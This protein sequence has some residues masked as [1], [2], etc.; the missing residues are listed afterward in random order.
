MEAEIPA[1]SLKAFSKALQCLARIGSDISLEAQPQHLELIGINASRSAYASFTFRNRF[2][3]AYRVDLLPGSQ[4]NPALRCRVLAKPLVGI[5][6]ARGPA[7]GHTVEKCFLRIEQATEPVHV[8]HAAGA[9]G[10]SSG[11]AQGLRQHS[12][13][14][15]G[16]SSPRHAGECRLVVRMEYKEGICRTHRLFY[17][18]CET[19][20][21][22]YD[23]TEY[24][25]RWR[26]GAKV[27][28]DWI[29]HFAR[30]QEEVSLW[31]ASSDVRVRS[32]SE[33]HYAGAGRTQI[34]AAVAD[35]TRALQTELTVAPA[36]FDEYVIAGTRPVELT[37]GLREFKA[38]LQYAEAMA[39]PL[40][41][42]FQ[43]AGTPLMLSVG[44]ARTAGH[45]TR[46]M[47]SQAPDDLSAE[48]V[49]A[50]LSEDML[51]QGASGPTA[52]SVGS[53][54]SPAGTSF[55]A[56]PQMARRDSPQVGSFTPHSARGV[57][58]SP[59]HIQGVITPSRPAVCERVDSISAQSEGHMS[60]NGSS[61]LRRGGHG[62][63]Y[64]IIDPKLV[65]TPS[66]YQSSRGSNT[67][68]GLWP[69]TGVAASRSDSLL[70][71]PASAAS[72][73]LQAV[74]GAAGRASAETSA[75]SYRLLDMPR[76]Q[77]PPGVTDAQ[78]ADEAGAPDGD[79]YEGIAPPGMVQT[80][81]PYPTAA[82]AGQQRGARACLAVADG[83]LDADSS[84]DDEL[85]A[86]PPPPSKRVR[87]LF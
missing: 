34:D 73:S 43:H 40:S 29:G 50:T 9:P 4:P 36:E 42:Y 41:A 48:F 24:K 14:S 46:G 61:G 31:M 2:F 76:P 65:P 57:G 66:P 71:L 28:A 20:H 54:A 25:S 59:I 3:D 60:S 7:T 81:L 52:S 35:T 72:A 62:S 58:A 39:H 53:A 1:A 85:E 56:G 82:A 63:V 17:E 83:A 87:S 33:G 15:G 21:P 5:F 68:H 12:S 79:R 49:L 19:L 51:S 44:A 27:A 78:P 18:V 64:D 6:K 70:S 23:K 37:F 26:V 67:E 32:W 69:S 47:Y 22:L 13:A 74:P 55:G 16:D 30:G 86:T 84:S 10:G 11:S 80:R 75:R 77:A 8:G 38:I 45:G